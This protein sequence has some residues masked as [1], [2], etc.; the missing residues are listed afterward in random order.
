M[1]IWGQYHEVFPCLHLYVV[2]KTCINN[3]LTKTTT[4]TTTINTYSYMQ[5]LL[6]AFTELGEAAIPELQL[7]SH[8]RIEVVKK[9]HTWYGSK[10]V[11]FI[12][13][14]N[15]LVYLWQLENLV[16]HFNNREH[17]M[18]HSVHVFSVLYEYFRHVAT[19]I[20]YLRFML[21]C[22]NIHYAITHCT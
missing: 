16:A 9:R 2:L 15:F 21:V 4:I 18:F 20:T 5:H 6:I 7:A 12:Y 11:I 1:F 22:I 8:Y 14:Y 3:L 19:I 17:F 10:C 13:F